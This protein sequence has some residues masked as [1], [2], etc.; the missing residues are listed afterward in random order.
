M[1][2][3]VDDA[4]LW[5]ACQR[6][7]SNDAPAGAEELEDA[8][9]ARGPHLCKNRRGLNLSWPTRQLA[10]PHCLQSSK[11][12]SCLSDLRNSDPFQC[13]WALI[14]Y[15]EIMDAIPTWEIKSTLKAI[16]CKPTKPCT[17]RKDN[18]IPS[19]IRTFE[20]LSQ[21]NERTVPNRKL[22]I[23]WLGIHICT[24]HMLP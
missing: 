19:H 11:H 13:C 23:S 1:L 22:R 4:M 12:R 15:G 14:H 18:I 5:R 9:M 10:Q 20:Q 17:L 8:L 16:T 24:S 21:L 7:Q 2:S 3:P 6:W